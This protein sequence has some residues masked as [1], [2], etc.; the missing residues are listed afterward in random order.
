ML[1]NPTKPP[2][3]CKNRLVSR[4]NNE[5]D[6]IFHSGCNILKDLNNLEIYE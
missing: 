2:Y 4:I 3:S 6:Y 5:T 1:K